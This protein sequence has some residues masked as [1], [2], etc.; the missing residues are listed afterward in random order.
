MRYKLSAYARR[1]ARNTSGVHDPHVL[2]FIAS[3]SDAHKLHSHVF[4]VNCAV[5]H[6]NS[7]KF[8][9]TLPHESASTS[10]VLQQ[11]R[12]QIATILQSLALSLRK[13]P[14]EDQSTSHLND[15]SCSSRRRRCLRKQDSQSTEAIQRFSQDSMHKK[16]TE[17][18]W[19]STMLAKKK[20]CFAIA[21]LLKDM[22]IQLHELNDYRTPNIGFFV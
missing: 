16:D 1:H 17:G 2:W 11:L 14:V 6:D 12:K 15:R 9:I 20:S 4:C 5:P 13:I 18:H 22:T 7:S 8:G 21:S 19:L 10:G 3:W